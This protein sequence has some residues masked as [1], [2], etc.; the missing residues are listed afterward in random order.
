MKMTTLLAL[1][2][3]RALTAWGGELLVPRQLPAKHENQV[4]LSIPLNFEMPEAPAATFQ[5]YFKRHGGKGDLKL[6]DAFLGEGG[7][8]IIATGFLPP[9]G[10]KGTY[11]LAGIF[12]QGQ[13]T[14]AAG[15]WLF[16][17][18]NCQRRSGDGETLSCYDNGARR[19]E[20]YFPVRLKT[21]AAAAVPEPG[22]RFENLRVSAR[23]ETPAPGGQKVVVAVSGSPL[24]FRY[25]VHY[26][27]F[28][29]GDSAY[30]QPQKLAELDPGR[31]AITISHTFPATPV[32]R[33]LTVE[34][35]YG[36]N[37]RGELVALL[38]GPHGKYEI[39][40]KGADDS[41][42]DPPKEHRVLDAPCAVVD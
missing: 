33:G 16:T 7:R 36:R 30:F 40:V 6:Q 18:A 1:A 9:G 19:S 10:K 27:V 5:A 15:G 38:C 42:Y 25:F 2:G 21:P 31:K 11:T 17:Q 13:E 41:L 26:V 32:L 34:K 35:L 4:V 22:G 20:S 3:F 12:Y 24:V 29:G 28:S 37:E 23:V 39:Q 8:S 14:S